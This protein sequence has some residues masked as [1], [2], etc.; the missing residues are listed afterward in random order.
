LKIQSDKIE[1]VETRTLIP[2]EKNMNK[3]SPEQIERLIKL[4]EYQGFRDPI[5]AQKGTNIIAAGHG[6]WEAAK[7]MG[8]EMVPV[9]FQ[10]F[11]NEAQ[12]Y[13]FVV[14]HNAIAK[15]S[16]ATLDL[17]SVNHEMLDLGPD[18]D[19]DMLGIKNFAIEPAE[20]DLPDLSAGDPTC[21]QVTFILST[22]QKDIMDEALKKAKR[23][24]DCTDEINQNEN[25]NSLAAILKRYVY[26]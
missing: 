18:F 2:Y 6:R 20:V 9:T 5:I 12:F 14:S 25:G 24:E 26:G 23:E 19:V 21:Q 22:E 4:I 10:E 8:L 3:H 13:A 11:E 15:D 16:W 1:L 17:S 7:K